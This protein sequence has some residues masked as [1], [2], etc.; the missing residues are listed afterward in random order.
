MNLSPIHVPKGAVTGTAMTPL[1]LMRCVARQ[2]TRGSD[3]ARLRF[4]IFAEVGLTDVRFRL[5]KRSVPTVSC[6]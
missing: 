2:L 6:T 4:T 5:N 1:S 3:V